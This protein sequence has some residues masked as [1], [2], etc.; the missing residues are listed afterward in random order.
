M[1]VSKKPRR[2]AAK[3][4]KNKKLR[5]IGQE[6]NGAQRRPIRIKKHRFQMLKE[7]GDFVAMVKIGRLVNAVS[8]GLEVLHVSRD[9]KTP[10]EKRQYYRALFLLGGYLHEGMELVASLFTRFQTEPF[11]QDLRK[12]RFDES[13]KVQRKM[14]KVIRNSVA[15]HLDHDD[16]STRSTLANLKIHRYDL[17]SA[18]TNTFGDFYFDLADTVDLNYLIDVLKEERTEPAT[19]ELIFKTVSEMMVEFLRG[20]HT[21]LTGLAEKMNFSDHTET[22]N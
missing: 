8:F 4:P 10:V 6:S 1:A 11:F 2:I 13:N 21:F 19:L 15:F 17:M 20:G 18:E 9:C 22:A 5:R 7:D 16:K 14:L 3:S 12:L